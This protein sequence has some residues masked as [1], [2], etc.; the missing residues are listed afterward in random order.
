MAASTY[1]GIMADLK[2]RKFA[3][4]YLL[5]GD[6]P[7]FIDQIASYIEKNALTDDEKT[8]NQT[9]VYGKDIDVPN[10]DTLSKRFPMMAEYQVVIVK[11]AQDMKKIDDL[12]FYVQK[13]QK[14]TILVL[15]HKYKELDKR[16]KLAS[17]IEKTGVVFTSKKLYDN[18]IPSWAESYIKEKGYTIDPV[19]LRLLTDYLGTDLSKIANEVDKLAI[20]L[21]SGSKI[22]PANI[23]DNIG[24]SKDYNNFELQNAI[25]SGDV[26]KAARIV[27]HFSKNQK[28]NPLVLTITALYGYFCKLLVFNQHIRDDSKTQAAALGCNPFFLKDYA[29]AQ[30]RFPAPKVIKAISLLREYDLKSKGVGNSSTDPGALLQELVYK[31]MH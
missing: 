13:P 15:C 16:K 11:E 20:A 22:S 8:F 25:G 28:D 18:K 1:E 6:E 7:Y 4:V 5:Q 14:T 2:A 9:V 21:P 24:I 3:P 19:A 23:Q 26:L 10:L 29:A 31:I 30:K 12:I 17:A 27:D